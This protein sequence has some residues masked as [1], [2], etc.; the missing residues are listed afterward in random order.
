MEGQEGGLSGLP[1]DV[2]WQPGCV[3]VPDTGR[4]SLVSAKCRAST[5][6]ELILH[7]VWLV[8]MS[9]QFSTYS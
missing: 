4:F 6:E 8:L 9:G 1:G 3:S 7:G 5:E 2:S